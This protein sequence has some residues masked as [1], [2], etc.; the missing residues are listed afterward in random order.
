M[1]H[2]HKGDEHGTKMHGHGRLNRKRLTRDGCEFIFC[3]PENP[4]IRS[5]KQGLLS[6]VQGI[7]KVLAVDAIRAVR[8]AGHGDLSPARVEDHRDHGSSGANSSDLPPGAIMEIDSLTSSHVDPEPPRATEL[9][10]HFSMLCQLGDG[11]PPPPHAAHS[12]SSDEMMRRATWVSHTD[13][14]TRCGRRSHS[15]GP[16]RHPLRLWMHVRSST[17]LDLPEVPNP[18]RISNESESD[19]YR[20]P[21]WVQLKMVRDRVV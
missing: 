2:E 20:I 12:C 7:G 19:T 6:R 10:Q 3:M 17:S 5:T 13:A 21:A 1:A 18:T 8:G 15:H 16:I 11:K 4:C 9:S 14:S